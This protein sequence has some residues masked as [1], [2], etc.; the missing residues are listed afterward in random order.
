[1]A[2]VMTIYDDK[3]HGLSGILM[4]HSLCF[5]ACKERRHFYHVIVWERGAWRRGFSLRLMGV[6][7][8]FRIFFMYSF[9]VMLFCCLHGGICW[10]L[11]DSFSA[12][13]AGL[14]TCFSSIQA[15]KAEFLFSV[16]VSPLPSQVRHRFFGVCLYPLCI[17][18][19]LSFQQCCK[20]YRISVALC[21]PFLSTSSLEGVLYWHIY[22][23]EF[24]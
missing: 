16:E 14:P 18:P 2:S 8:L 10:A 12:S 13:P 4:Y 22:N 15:W 20:L 9:L 1:M 11:G 19:S 3:R 5:R 23:I 17:L 21:V 6:S 7:S 24:N